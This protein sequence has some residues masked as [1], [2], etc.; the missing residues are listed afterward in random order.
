[1]IFAL[2]PY[3]EVHID[4][5]I[6]QVIV[7]SNYKTTSLHFQRVP[8]EV[9]FTKQ[10]SLFVTK[11]SCLP[12]STHV[13]YATRWCCVQQLFDVAIFNTVTVIRCDH[14][15]SNGRK[16]T[17]KVNHKKVTIF[18]MSCPDVV[19]GTCLGSSKLGH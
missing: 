12:F 13:S 2:L 5:I 19:N 18:E 16:F 11:K 10:D 9:T 17:I 15:L 8:T 6:S 3:L 1:M 14:Y 4:V 7:I